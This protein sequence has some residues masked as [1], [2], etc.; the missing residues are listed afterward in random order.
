MTTLCNS[1]ITPVLG[2]VQDLSRRRGQLRKGEALWPAR[3]HLFFTGRSAAEFAILQDSIVS[4]ARSGV[5]IS[6]FMQKSNHHRHSVP[7]A[8]CIAVHSW[9][10]WGGRSV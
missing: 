10:I 6:L 7:S 9:C 5:Q 4:D 3:A 8:A 2:L 1:Q